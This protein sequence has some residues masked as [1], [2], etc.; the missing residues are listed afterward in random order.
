MTP[1][2]LEK[3][4]ALVTGASSGIGAAI[5]RELA[6]RKVN[7]VLTAR[8]SDRLE[9]LAKDLR[10]Y[11]I[12]VDIEVGDLLDLTFRE[13]LLARYCRGEQACEILINNAAFGM[14]GR[15]LDADPERLL[16]LVELGLRTPMELARAF[17]EAGCERGEG[18][19]LNLASVAAFVPTPFHALYSATKAG[20]KSF[21]LT[22]AAEVAK[23]GVRVTALCPGVTNTEFFDAGKYSTQS[24]VYRMK[25]MDA[26]EVAKIGLDALLRGQVQVVPGFRNRLL[27]KLGTKIPRSWLTKAAAKTMSTD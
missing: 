14:N 17:A 3:K 10:T 7:L 6:R 12:T 27:L 4:R 13:S 1:F 22:L 26:A 8:R 18:A 23:Q 21:S 2:E 19:I 11:G 15:F 24:P 25:R 20:L 16:D 5:A 9:T